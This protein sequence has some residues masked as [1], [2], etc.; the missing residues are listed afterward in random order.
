MNEHQPTPPI[1]SKLRDR[2]LAAEPATPTTRYTRDLNDL[3]LGKL[4]GTRRI[5]LVV[6]AAF[7]LA[8]GA[9]SAWLAARPAPPLP[10]AARW[11]LGF[12]AACCLAW[13]AA[14]VRTLRAGVLHRRRHVA[15]FTAIPAVVSLVTG[16]LLIGLG[17]EQSDVIR[18]V[19]TG[20]LGVL[21]LIVAAQLLLQN[22]VEQSELRTRERLLEIQLQLAELAE[23]VGGP[24]PPATTR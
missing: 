21:C 11:G 19:R 23:A 15:T 13:A 14:A 22:V 8:A 1:P 20:F 18:V 9:G 24:N 5:A 10:P 3:L 4:S 16:V 12:G 6:A 17:L 2:L 7:A